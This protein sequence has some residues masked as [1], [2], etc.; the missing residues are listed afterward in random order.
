MFIVLTHFLHHVLLFELLKCQGSLFIFLFFIFH[1][2]VSVYSMGSDIVIVNVVN[3]S[4]CHWLRQ[5]LDR[6]LKLVFPEVHPI[7]LLLRHSNFDINFLLIF[8]NLSSQTELNS[9]LDRVKPLIAFKLKLKM[10]YIK[11]LD[12]DCQR[13]LVLSIREEV[14]QGT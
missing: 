4:H 10:V 1:Q 3:R 2:F 6:M 5:I 9:L 12:T 11:D 13:V 14:L 7:E 8:I